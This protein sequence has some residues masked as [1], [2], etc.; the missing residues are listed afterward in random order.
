MIPDWIICLVAFCGTLAA[1]WVDRKVF[2]DNKE[3]RPK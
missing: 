1:L 3:D 2:F